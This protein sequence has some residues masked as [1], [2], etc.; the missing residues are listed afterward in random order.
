MLKCKLTAVGIEYNYVTV[1][2]QNN[3][4]FNFDLDPITLINSN[5]IKTAVFLLRVLF[6]VRGNF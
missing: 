1:I 6:T 4:I 5:Y 2:A 3:E